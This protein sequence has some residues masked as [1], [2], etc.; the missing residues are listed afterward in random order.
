MTAPKQPKIT[1]ATGASHKA[2]ASLLGHILLTSLQQS[3]EHQITAEVSGGAVQYVHGPVDMVKW[4]DLHIIHDA[5]KAAIV[6]TEMARPELLKC[7]PYLLTM[8]SGWNPG[9]ELWGDASEGAGFDIQKI[10]I[11]VDVLLAGLKRDAVNDADD[12]GMMDLD[13]IQRE[14]MRQVIR[15]TLHAT[16]GKRLAQPVDVRA[17][18]SELRLEGKLGAKPSQANFHPVQTTLSGRFAGFD[19]QKKELLFLT[20]ERCVHLNF[21]PQQVDL[22]QVTRSA[23]EELDCEVRTHQTTGRNGRHDHAYLPDIPFKSSVT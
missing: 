7:E 3:Q 20:P 10:N 22:L 16:G 11:V 4:K 9:L 5:I 23:I 8:G 15:E 2:A 21:E 18:E 19:L 13:P 6:R 17:G 12:I 1:A 14:A